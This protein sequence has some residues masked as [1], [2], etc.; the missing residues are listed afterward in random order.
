MDGPEAALT[1]SIVVTLAA[2]GF[3]AGVASACFPRA[4]WIVA[5]V[6]M[7]GYV[8]LLIVTSVYTAACTSCTSHISYDSSRPIDL[9]V[10]VFWGALFTAGIVLCTAAGTLSATLFRRLFL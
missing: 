10:A 1:L 7:A 6:V 9:V 4:P 3:G 2:L 5:G 8:V